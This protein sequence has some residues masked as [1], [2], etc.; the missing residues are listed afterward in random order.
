MNW[1][2]R[3]AWIYKDTQPDLAKAKKYGVEVIYLDPRASNAAAVRDAIRASNLVAGLY[4]ASN[5]YGANVIGDAFGRLAATVANR[6]IP[7]PPN[8]EAPPLMLDLEGRTKTW[9]LGALTEYRRY[10]PARPT[11]VTT[12]PFKDGTVLP[13][14]EFRAADVEWYP[15]LYHGDMSPADPAAVVLDASR[16]LGDATKVHPFYDG[17]HFPGDARDGC[18]FTL[19]RLP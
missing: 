2:A 18:I 12:E 4:V 11:A 5:W 13:L 6:V 15:Q 10:E 16:W 14:A 8:A 3:A 17:A 7:R 19:E 9:M 1:S